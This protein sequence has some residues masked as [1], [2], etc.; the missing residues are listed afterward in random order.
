MLRDALLE[1][2][3]SCVGWFGRIQHAQP[4]RSDA[5][6]L[7]FLRHQGIRRFEVSEEIHSELSSTLVV[8]ATNPG[9]VGLFHSGSHIGVDMHRY[10]RGAPRSA[11]HAI[12]P[13]L[14]LRS[15]STLP[16]PFVL[17]RR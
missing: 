13:A 16:P 14:S 7:N 6:A 8:E 11:S 5:D 2:G 4:R 3:G 9:T 10:R 15:W 12:D 17:R 1:R